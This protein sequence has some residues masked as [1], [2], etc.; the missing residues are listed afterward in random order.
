MLTPTHIR[1][2]RSLI[3]ARQSDLAKAA[4]ISLATLNNIERNVG[5]P[6]ASTLAAIETALAQ[7]GVLVEDSA[8]RVGV[9]VDRF[10][11][12]RLFEPYQA[13]EAIMAA[14]GPKALF[15]A[16]AVVA[17]GRRGG[18]REG[19]AHPPRFCVALTGRLRTQVFD[20]AS[21]ALDSPAGAA[22]VC[23]ILIAA[24]AYRRKVLRYI[25]H[26]L[27]D[28]TQLGDADVVARIAAAQPRPMTHPAQI[29]DVIDDWDLLGDT[30]LSWKSHPARDLLLSFGPPPATQG[31]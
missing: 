12:P 6:R 15:M 20:R 23:G 5:D 4:G 7:A 19:G 29:V 26:V 14:I 27:D 1:A 3:G 24:F 16:D 10:S 21:L 11:R 22:E 13:S 2:A 8:D 28:T 30:Y 17:Y 9:A 18:S 25:D 31:G